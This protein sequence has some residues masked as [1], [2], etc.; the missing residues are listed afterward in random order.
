MC[1]AREMC[2]IPGISSPELCSCRLVR[3]GIISYC[4]QPPH[5]T[6]NLE[7][8][9]EEE[10]GSS[11]ADRNWHKAGAGIME[12]DDCQVTTVFTV[13]PSFHHRHSTDRVSLSVTIVGER[14]DEV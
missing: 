14:R 8:Q 13:Q 2:D 7:K 12:A 5:H 9:T 10:E 11:G 3:G 4:Q 1:T 6:D